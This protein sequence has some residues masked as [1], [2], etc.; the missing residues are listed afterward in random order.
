MKIQNLK[1]L[2]SGIIKYKLFG[3]K[4]PLNVMIS[5]TD[6]CNLRCKYC[7]IPSR[8]SKE[9]SKNKIIT[10]IDDLAKSGTQRIGLWGGEPLIRNDI[11]DIIKYI[12]SKNIYLTLDTNGFLFRQRLEGLKLV[13]K[14]V[15]SF[16]GDTNAH[17]ILRGKNSFNRTIQAIELAKLNKIN[18]M[19]LMVLTKYNIEQIEYVLNIAKNKKFKVFFQPLYHSNSLAGNTDELLPNKKKYENAIKKLLIKKTQNQPIACSKNYLQY[20]LKRSQNKKI[21]MKC[22]ASKL[23]CNI[24]TNGKLYPCSLLVDNKSYGQ[25][26]ETNFMSSFKKLKTINK[27]CSF[28][29]GPFVEYNKIFGMDS[30]VIF[31]WLKNTKSNR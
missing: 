13:D 30:S 18:V 8:N 6:R 1:G 19:T 15:I 17:E 23:F 7:E 24:D 28:C 20:L 25:G 14:V 2:G 4:N 22:Y 29:S 12:K 31:N 11:I 3:I 9:L 16:E 21:K 27:Y 10:L 26:I 5:I